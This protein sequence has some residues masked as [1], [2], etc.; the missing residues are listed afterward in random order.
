MRC[1]SYLFLITALAAQAPQS[2]VTSHDE[3]LTFQSSVNLVRVPVVVRDKAGHPV[4]GLQKSDFHLTDLGKPQEIAQ[5]SLEGTAAAKQ[6]GT[7]VQ[8]RI[9]GE[10]AESAHPVVP[11]RFVTF[12][13]DDVHLKTEELNSVRVAAL[14]LLEKGI[15][16][17]ERVGILTL[18]GTVSLDLTND[19]AKFRET[20][21][22]IV[23]IPV[24]S[25][26]PP[27]SFFMAQQFM[28]SPGDESL[29]CSSTPT[30]S[31]TCDPRMPQV[32]ITQTAVTAD[33]LHLTCE[34]ISEAPPIARASLRA[35][36]NDGSSE[37]YNS[38]H[39]LNNIVRL[40]G[41][42]PGDRVMI[43]VSP[44]IYL[45]DDLQRSLSDSIDRA[46]HSGVTINTLD[47]RGV[48]T[49]DPAVGVH[50]CA[51]TNPQT[52]QQL[53]QLDHEAITAQGLLLN[54][55]A[56]ST[57][58]TAVHDNDFLGGLDRLSSPPDYVYYLGYYPRDLKPDGKFHEIKVTLAKGT[59]LSV[60]ARKGYW[61]A[62][63]AEDAAAASTREIGEAVF[64]HDEL[65]DLP[66]DLDTQF[67]KT[68]DGDAR[69]KIVAHLDIRQLHLRK[70]DDLNRDDVTV[71]YALFDG[72]GNYLKGVKK[73]VE[74]RLKDQSVDRRRDLGLTMHTEFDVKRGAYMVRVVA[75][76]AEG[77]QMSAANDVVEIP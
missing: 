22:K 58:G 61:A 24:Q 5:F 37:V 77:R 7:Q 49:I 42:M 71:V 27:A 1:W 50:G 12:V 54:T 36:Y 47:A 30:C 14:K 73:V 28:R 43:L 11:T 69:L 23:P 74:L 65:R 15:P 19:A 59:G 55:L 53:S 72:N 29:G 9:P 56:D 39:M 46:T 52:Q 67:Y 21:A 45:P 57:G 18:S 40:L 8:L 13:F 2:E 60:H 70:A 35:V 64:S 20:L 66:L 48:Y 6:P 4:G 51:L 68:T 34:Q 26:F 32:L 62:Q 41:S 76:D 10:P 3:T 17:Q 38:F 25:H 31:V 63:Q 44:G 75:R 33:C 16:P